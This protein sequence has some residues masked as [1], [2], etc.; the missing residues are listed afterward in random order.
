MWIVSVFQ[1][2]A[3]VLDVGVPPLPGRVMPGRPLP[4]AAWSGPRYGAVMVVE[5]W[6]V[7]GDEDGEPFNAMIYTYRRVDGAWE[8]NNGTGGSEWPGGVSTSAQIGLDDREVLLEGG[9]YGGTWTCRL[10][11][12]FGGREAT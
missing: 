2:F 12:G 11:E 10:V 5:Q 6:D 4:V 1:N 7:P 3:W 9:E 8:A